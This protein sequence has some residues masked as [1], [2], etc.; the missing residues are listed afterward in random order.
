[1]L[2]EWEVRASVEG[3]NVEEVRSWDWR[4]VMIVQ[5]GLRGCMEEGALEGQSLDRCN[6]QSRFL[7]R[8]RLAARL[9][10]PISHL[11][12][13]AFGT[14]FR[15]WNALSLCNFGWRRLRGDRRRGWGRV[16]L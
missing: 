5:G 8:S 3:T 4:E 16:G 1:M 9:G 14:W 15:P 12:Q 10:R 11:S 7:L 6:L 2:W 13:S